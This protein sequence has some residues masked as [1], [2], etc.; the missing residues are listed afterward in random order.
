M[1][2]KDEKRLLV[3]LKEIQNFKE[4]KFFDTKIIDTGHD[5]FSSETHTFKPDREDINKTLKAATNLNY[6]SPMI[7]DLNSED[8]EL[9]ELT[10]TGI[11][12]IEELESKEN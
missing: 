9:Y 5:Y 4:I 11:K 8:V 10:D 7:Y 12:K 6:I 3:I 1:L 2:T